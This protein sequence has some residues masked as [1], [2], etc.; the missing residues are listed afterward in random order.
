M[1]LAIVKSA[2]ALEALTF[3][4]KDLLLS[5][6]TPTAQAIAYYGTTAASA[7]GTAHSAHYARRRS[8]CSE[9]A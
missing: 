3:L 8:G 6:R 2:T 4:K 1:L 7:A 9:H 5:V